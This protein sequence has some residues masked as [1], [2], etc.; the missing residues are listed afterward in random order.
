MLKPLADDTE[1]PQKPHCIG[2]GSPSPH[3]LNQIISAVLQKRLSSSSE[4]E[5]LEWLGFMAGDQDAPL[6]VLG[7]KIG[8]ALKEVS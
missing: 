3:I 6:Q 7:A 8:V 1:E 2:S 4:V 5:L